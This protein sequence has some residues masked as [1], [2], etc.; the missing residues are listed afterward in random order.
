[1]KVKV[2]YFAVTEDCRSFRSDELVDINQ[3]INDLVEIKNKY[4]AKAP[5]FK[6]VDGKIVYNDEEDK[7]YV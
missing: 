2:V 6:K 1:M 7:R 3:A 4:N 5:D